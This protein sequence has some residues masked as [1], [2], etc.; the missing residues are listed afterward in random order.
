M[1]FIRNIKALRIF[2][3]LFILFTV[4]LF[5]FGQSDSTENKIYYYE[6]IGVVYTVRP[7]TTVGVEETQTFN[8]VSGEFHQG[9]REIPKNKIDGIS[10]VKVI[11]VD[12]GEEYVYSRSKLDK[13]NP[14]SWGRYTTFN[15]NG[16]TIIEW[17]YNGS[18]GLRTWKLDYTLH[19]A[20][21]FFSNVDEL[22]LNV[23]DAY[24]VPVKSVQARVVLP[25]GATV[26]RGEAFRTNK[27]IVVVNNGAAFST[28]EI[29]PNEAFTI[30]VS[31]PKG[32]VDK[33][34][35][36]Y[37][38]FLRFYYGIIT[39][40]FLVVGSFL[41]SLLYILIRRKKEKEGRGTIVP[42]YE[43]PKNLRPLVAEVITKGYVTNKG[44][45]AT[46]VDLAVRGYVSIEEDEFSR[47]SL[48][49]K[50]KESAIVNKIKIRRIPMIVFIGALFSFFALLDNSR[51][52]FFLFFALFIIS[53]IISMFS[54]STDYIV[55]KIKNYDADSTLEDFE[56]TYLNILFSNSDVFSTRALRSMTAYVERQG[57]SVAVQN[58]KQ[59]VLKEVEKDTNAYTQSISRSQNFFGI[60]FVLFMACIFILI[61]LSSLWGMQFSFVLIG[62]CVLF[63]VLLWIF[64]YRTILSKEGRILREEWL[65]FKLYLKTA[66]KYRLENLTPETFEKFLPYA[67]VFGL[68]KKWAGAFEK[69]N[70]PPPNWYHGAVVGGAIG[71]SSA[72]S[73]S[74]SSFSSNF[75]SS[76]SSAFS[77]SGAGG[78]GGGGSAG[79]GGGGGGGGAS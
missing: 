21:G 60:A 27:D 39:L 55:K 30:Q 29:A 35:Y 37:K 66:E 38:S 10:D 46:I 79:G 32:F 74:P 68:E 19:G 16:K 63:V 53:L 6:N 61:S 31:W 43:P 13:T 9:W 56:K 64:K 62:L 71:S 76:F 18:N 1:A 45:S 7:D 72:S 24:S 44:L 36:F 49:K 34:Q 70:V 11:D 73:F 41:F 25:D 22:Y 26:S 40:G 59:S 52:G 14:S 5:V 75:S 78:G 47:F 20:I 28:P 23:L 67:M 12:S 54:R 51:F 77:S 48:A 17:Y 4:P 65:G 57:F 3:V 58:L 50:I 15:Q 33:N 42:E 69:M 2:G 8:F